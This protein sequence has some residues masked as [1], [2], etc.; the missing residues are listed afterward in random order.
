MTHPHVWAQGTLQ[1]CQAFKSNLGEYRAKAAKALGNDS[2][3]VPDDV[4]LVR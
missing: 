2:W 1:V 3:D 4:V